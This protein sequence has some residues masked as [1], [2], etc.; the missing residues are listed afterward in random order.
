QEV[1]PDPQNPMAAM[2]AN[3]SSDLGPLLGAWGLE[4]SPEEIAGNRDLALRVNFQNQA[5]DYLVYLGLR[6]QKD[7]QK[8]GGF[9]K[10][11][12]VTSQLDS[13]NMATVGIL[14]KKDGATETIT[15]LLETT[16]NSMKIQ[17]SLVQFGP[18]PKRMLESFVS[19]KEKMMLA[20]RV[21]GPAK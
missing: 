11:D 20:A 19:G 6:R 4:M 9:S 8:D 16:A 7:E 3:R 17:K 13:M 2:M 21:N 1:R 12:V 14:R 18:D 5:V 10:Q 15:P